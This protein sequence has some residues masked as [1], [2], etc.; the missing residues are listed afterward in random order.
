MHSQNVDSRRSV[1]LPHQK[2][3]PRAW[4]VGEGCTSRVRVE[5]GL[6]PGPLLAPSAVACVSPAEVGFLKA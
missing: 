3:C 6:R 1:F 4:T 2:S 5:M